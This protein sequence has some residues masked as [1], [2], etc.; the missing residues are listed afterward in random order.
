MVGQRGVAGGS[1]G[2]DVDD[3][4][5]EGAVGAVLDHGVSGLWGGEDGGDGARSSPCGDVAGTS[6]GG[7]ELGLGWRHIDLDTVADG[8]RGRN[9]ILV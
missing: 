4:S 8:E 9:T 7:V 5:V 3:G 6:A 2:T 1:V